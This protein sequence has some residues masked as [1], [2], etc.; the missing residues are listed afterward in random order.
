MRVLSLFDGMACGY[1]ALLKA[2]I[3]VD[4][5]Y[6]SEIDKYAIQ[7]AMKN[8]PDIIQVGDVTKLKGEDFKDVDMIIGGSP[9]QG[10]SMAWKML[11]FNDPR[12]K[13]FFE[14]V[15]LVKEIKPKYFLLENVK[16]K[17]EFQDVISEYMW[18]Q[19]IEINSA[20]VSAQNRK[21]LYRTNIPWV[22]Q[23]EDKGILLKDILET[24]VDEKYDLTERQL[25]T[26][27]RDFGSKGKI[28]DNSEIKTNTITASMWTWWWNVPC[29]VRWRPKMPY[30]PW[31]R[32]LEYKQYSDKC[33]TL[34]ENCA[35]GDQK[36]TVIQ[37]LVSVRG[38][39]LRIRQA[40]KQWYIVANEWDGVS[41]AYPNSTT[42]RGRVTKQKS[43][44]LMA[45]WDSYVVQKV[46]DRDKNNRWVHTDKSYCLPAN[47]MSDRWQMVVEW[48]RIRK[49][50][51]I[52]CERLQ[53]M[54]DNYTEW[55]SDTQ[56]YKM[57]WN[58]W[59]CDV[60]AH[61]FSFIKTD[62]G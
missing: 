49:L 58:W 24:D 52:E 45:S 61:I 10:F 28:Y 4:K 31:H 33:P 1:E 15:R 16:M 27:N 41:L 57:L 20:L 18:V 34:T 13:L 46:W 48:L 25:K 60:I 39:K 14:F 44:T 32:E 12:S 29:I 37:P 42:R 30:E 11:N 9:C 59:T 51:P 47:P 55:V 54:P 53:T 3:K 40:T 43:N 62:N 56:R 5:Y 6:A 23:P 50:T 38:G 35:S 21:R 7:I 22:T 2:W 19:P 8:H 17:K 26:M 36:N